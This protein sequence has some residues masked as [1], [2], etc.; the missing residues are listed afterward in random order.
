MKFEA[1]IGNL[2]LGH[3]ARLGGTKDGALVLCESKYFAFCPS[4]VGWLSWLKHRPVHQRV[5]S[6]IPGRGTYLVC[7]FEPG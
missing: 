5:V 4:R 3:T 6:S 7:G 1:G 2:S